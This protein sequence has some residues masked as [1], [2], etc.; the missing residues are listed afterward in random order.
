ML[1]SYPIYKHCG[2]LRPFAMALTK[3]LKTSFGAGLLQ[4]AV[5]IL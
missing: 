5:S 2:F 4:G 3:S 1:S